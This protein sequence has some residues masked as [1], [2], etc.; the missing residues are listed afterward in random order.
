MIPGDLLDFDLRPHVIQ[1]EDFVLLEVS[2]KDGFRDVCK[3][4][5]D[6]SR[7]EVAAALRR[8]ADR[9]ERKI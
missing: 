1:R 7:H 3:W 2:D 5:L 9:L 8:L 6:A 4:H